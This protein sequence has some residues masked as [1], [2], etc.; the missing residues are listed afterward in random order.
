MSHTL[1]PEAEN[2][3]TVGL[4]RFVRQC[5]WIRRKEGSAAS[6]TWARSGGLNLV[7]DVSV[8]FKYAARLVE[9]LYKGLRFVAN[10]V[11]DLVSL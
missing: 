6:N 10:L 9:S 5:A 11:S 2:G 3:A 7:G 8:A 4:R 1:E